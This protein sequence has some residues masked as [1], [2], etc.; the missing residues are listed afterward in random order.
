MN[1]SLQTNELLKN[2]TNNWELAKKNYSD[3]KLVKIKEFNMDGFSF[4]VQFNPG[5]IRSSAAKV[6]KESIEKRPCFLC[7]KNRPIEQKSVQFNADFQILINP[8][9]IFNKHLTII[10]S[11]HVKQQFIPYFNVMLNLSKE[12]K[13]F[14][15][16]Y[17]GAKCGASAPDH[18]HFQAGNKQYM[19]IEKD[20]EQLKSKYGSEQKSNNGSVFK[21]NDGFRRFFIVESSDTKFIR[22]FF[23]KFYEQIKPFK[24][25]EYEP[26]MNIITLY[27]N[28]C[29]R[30]FIFPRGAYRPWQ[31]SAE[32][33]QN[34]V[35]TP[36]AVE[37]GG[38]LITPLEKDFKKLTINDVKDIFNQV[39]IDK[40]AF[41]HINFD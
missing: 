11:K 1:Y 2:Q 28:T 41:E 19:P 25:Y 5:R 9:P 33:E 35:L 36:A 13:E 16:F 24:N 34:I 17:N 29:W 23:T 27:Q 30:L 10:N 26:D 18:F 14:S 15:I 6:D 32:G 39:S 37:F 12:L 40:K 4:K 3:L 20:V 7:N 8:F 22:N 21:I 31:Y 38:I